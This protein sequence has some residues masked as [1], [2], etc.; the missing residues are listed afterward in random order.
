[1]AHS[2]LI[3]YVGKIFVSRMEIYKIII[4]HFRRT[5]LFHAE[6]RIGN[7]QFG[8]Y[9][10]VTQRI[11]I[12]QPLETFYCFLIAAFL[13]VI[14]SFLIE[15]FRITFRHILTFPPGTAREEKDDRYWQ[16]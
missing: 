8:T 7:P 12:L 6:L 9:R 14:I 13:V 2:N 11:F 16:K 15:R 4:G 5:V 1:M 10:Q 3:H